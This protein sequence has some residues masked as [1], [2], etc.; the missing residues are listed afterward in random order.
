MAFVDGFTILARNA[1]SLE[2]HDW[3]WRPN[4][5]VG[6]KKIARAHRAI[7]IEK[8]KSKDPFLLQQLYVHGALAAVLLAC[9][10]MFPAQYKGLHPKTLEQAGLTANPDQDTSGQP[11]HD[12]LEEFISANYSSDNDRS[13]RSL[14]R[15]GDEAVKG[16]EPP[17]DAEST[18]NALSIFVKP[19]N[20][21]H[22]MEILKDKRFRKDELYA[23]KEVTPQY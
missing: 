13:I 2:Q 7:V 12:Q 3:F 20:R 21:A 16:Q 23:L 22:Y 17:K 1:A 14:L 9:G 4:R 5:E 19:A 8:Q 15:L 11:A 6:E 18:P 10:Y